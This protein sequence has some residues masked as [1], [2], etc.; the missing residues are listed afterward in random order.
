ML[1][2][3]VI[4]ICNAPQ[5]SLLTI[6][7]CVCILLICIDFTWHV[8]NLY[9]LYDGTMSVS[10]WKLH[11]YNYNKI[12]STTCYIT[13]DVLKYTYVNNVFILYALYCY[14][15]ITLLLFIQ[16]SIE[17]YKTLLLEINRYYIRYHAVNC[18]V[19]TQLTG[20]AHS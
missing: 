1:S 4:Y 10:Y 14:S 3:T 18:K 7:W 5:I 17:L 9:G 2:I 12:S 16:H 8:H 20:V 19:R 13:I 6:L 15:N 11:T